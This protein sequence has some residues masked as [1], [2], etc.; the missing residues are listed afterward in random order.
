MFQIVCKLCVGCVCLGWWWLL[1]LLMTR[2]MTLHQRLIRRVI[3]LISFNQI[4]V[5][6]STNMKLVSSLSCGSI[7]VKST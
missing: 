7:V 2:S 6:S 1:C 3:A 4:R 5:K